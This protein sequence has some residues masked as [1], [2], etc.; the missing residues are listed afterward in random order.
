MNASGTTT[1]TSYDDLAGAAGPSVTVNIPASGKALVTVTA[2][3]T[4]DTGSAQDYMGFSV[5]NGQGPL[6]AMSYES[7]QPPAG[8]ALGNV[9]VDATYQGS[10]TYL[11]TG[12]TPGATTFTAKYRVTSGEGT[13]SMRSIVVLPLG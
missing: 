5:S 6:D 1:S 7:E 4:N 12:L 3:E 9:P 2:S 13:F 11:V 10:G 8:G